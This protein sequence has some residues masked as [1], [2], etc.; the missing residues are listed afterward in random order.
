[1][2]ATDDLARQNMVDAVITG[3]TIVDGTGLA[4]FRADLALDQ[5]RIRIVSDASTLPT[6]RTIKAD[7]LVVAPGFIDA[8]SHNDLVAVTGAGLNDKV[9]QGVTTEVFGNCGFSAFPVSDLNAHLAPDL[10]SLIAPKQIERSAGVAWSGWAAFAS[11]VRKAGCQS[12]VVGQVGHIMLRSAVMGMA[13]RA[14]HETELRAMQSLL[15]QSLVEG[16]SGLSFGLMYHPSSYAEKDE[17]RA[18]CQ[19]AADHGA[20]VSVHLRGYDL[21]TL[22]S[23][24]EEMLSV[25]EATGVRL[26]L[27]HLSPTGT[28]AQE[29]TESML[30]L[31]DR[32]SERGV[33]VSIDRYPYEQGM[34]RLA[35]IFPKWVVADS[36]ERMLERLSDPGLIA[37]M[38]VEIDRFV[39][40]IGYDQIVLMR[41]CDPALIGKSLL[42]VSVLLAISPAAAAVHVMR[43]SAGAAGIVLTLSTMQTQEKV[44]RHCLCMVGSDGMPALGGTHPR[45]FGTFARIAGPFV[46]RGV[47]SLENAVYKM[48]GLTAQRFGLIDRGQVKDDFIADL[49][50]F[51]PQRIGDRSTFEDSYA[52]AD[53][54]HEVI[55]AG[56]SV[57]RGG[58]SLSAYPGAV[59][60]CRVGR[61]S[62]GHVQ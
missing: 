7:G 52:V 54:V 5:G 30:E 12:N 33:D 25:A 3:G 41:N 20:L 42:E 58:Q 47:L 9:S 8:H 49:V 46:R 32:S 55:V 27:S 60:T 48:T 6:R 45:T 37:R 1:M 38:S 51:D 50:L 56:E 16:A 15:A 44:I 23:S 18:L 36:L 53:G 39:Q 43:D 26:Q 2:R 24:M 61:S 22:A 40:A 28:D 31:V 29:L 11:A 35:L 14:P 34:S 19:V 57:Y 59:L 21:A 10:M 4:P 62:T 17:I 13:M